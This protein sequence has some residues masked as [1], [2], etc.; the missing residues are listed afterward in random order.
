MIILYWLPKWWPYT[1]MALCF[2]IVAR[3]GEALSW[4]TRNHE[5]LH[6]HQQ[7]E[8]LFLPFFLW[9]GIEFLVRLIQYRNWVDAY[10]NISFER[11]AYTWE[12][13]FRY[14]TLHRQP[15]GWAKYLKV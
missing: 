1:A 14:L 7:R 9:Y 8:M 15:F 12:D 11:E 10:R 6:L 5:Y 4:R 3:R 2:V 13:D